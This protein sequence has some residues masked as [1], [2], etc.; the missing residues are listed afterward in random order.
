MCY[1]CFWP[2][3]LCW[4]ASLRPMA[5]RTRFVFLMHPKEF[6]EEKAGTGR[7]THLCLT[8]SEIRMGVGFDG[9]VAVQALINDPRNLPVL[10]YPGMEALNL[11]EV[12]RGV[13]AEPRLTEDGSPYLSIESLRSQLEHRQLVVFLLDATWRGARKMLQQ[14]PSLQRLPRIMFTPSAPSR[15]IIKQQPVEGCLSTLEAVHEL[16]TVLERTGLD[17]YPL[18]AQLLEV[19]QRMQDFQIKCA[20][21]PDRGGYRRH[22]YSAPEERIPA[23]GRSGKRRTQHLRRPLQSRPGGTS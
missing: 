5:T 3:S 13:P 11:S 22:P 2:Q 9:D 8:N 1:R 18:P 23:H 10:L 17:A 14:S 19:F 15:Y 21:D 12:G 16:L 6:K 20:A 4:C 7:L